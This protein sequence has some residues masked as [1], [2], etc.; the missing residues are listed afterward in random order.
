MKKGLNLSALAKQAAKIKIAKRLDSMEDAP[1]F[2]KKMEKG[3]KML[4]IAGLPKR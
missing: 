4:A 3:A 2:K 1:F